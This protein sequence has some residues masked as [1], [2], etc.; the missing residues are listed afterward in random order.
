MACNAATSDCVIARKL[1]SCNSV[2]AKAERMKDKL[3]W[4]RLY[5]GL[6]YCIIVEDIGREEFSE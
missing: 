4:R 6:H 1:K 3:P 2:N 5:Y